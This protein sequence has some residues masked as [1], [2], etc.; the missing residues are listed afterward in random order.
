MVVSISTFTVPASPY[1]GACPATATFYGVLTTNRPITVVYQWERS[2]AIVNGPYSQ[3]VGSSSAIIA[4]Q[5]KSIPS[6]TS[7]E[8]VVVL[9][10]NSIASNQTSFTNSCH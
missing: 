8:R 2:D 5:W 6:G 3:S 9:M 7:W 4:D 1:A 10:P